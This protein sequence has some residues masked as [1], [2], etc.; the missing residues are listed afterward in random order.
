[1]LQRSVSS[2]FSNPL[3]TP[4]KGAAQIMPIKSWCRIPFCWLVLLLPAFP[5]AAQLSSVPSAP[6]RNAY[7]AASEGRYE[8]AL[9]E[10]LRILNAAR[11]TTLIA[12]I[13]VQT[14]ELFRVHQVASDGRGLIASAEG[15][16][17]G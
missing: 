10:Y 13:A 16:V 14:G 1:M 2:S 3:F 11:D 4:P 15:G 9:E 12:E 8:D 7:Y 5:A 17:L 6:L